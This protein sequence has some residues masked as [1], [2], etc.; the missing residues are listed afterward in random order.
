MV[1]VA[2]LAAEVMVVALV[3][4]VMALAAAVLQARGSR[5]AAA[6]SE[7]AGPQL[8]VATSATVALGT[9]VLA[10]A[11][12]VTA[13]CTVTAMTTAGIR[14]GAIAIHTTR[15][16]TVT[17]IIGDTGARAVL[18]FWTRS[19]GRRDWKG[20]ASDR[21]HGSRGADLSP[22]T[23]MSIQR[24]L[25]ICTIIFVASRSIAVA[26]PCSQAIDS[27]QAQ[28]DAKLEAKAAAGPSARE[29]TAATLNHQPTPNSIAAAEAKLGEIS[30]ETVQALKAAMAQAR[31]ADRAGD[32][33]ACERALADAQGI[34]A[35]K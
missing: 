14:D 12:M 33:S 20:A 10:E 5:R 11:S 3:A 17:G 29:S 21:A 13:A 8:T 34:L 9:V 26:G 4:E 1:V 28:F 24:S 35:Q 23:I 31:E 19:R 27:L 16:T 6:T 2:A 18:D 30:P 32:K 22:G 25:V 7:A 15:R